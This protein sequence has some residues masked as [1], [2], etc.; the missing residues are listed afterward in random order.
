VRKRLNRLRLATKGSAVFTIDGETLE[1]RAGQILV[2]PA[3][4]AHGSISSGTSRCAR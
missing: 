3:G 1:A 2:A 4:A